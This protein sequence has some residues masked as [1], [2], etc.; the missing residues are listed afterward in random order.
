MS[1]IG[2]FKV[3][4][5]SYVVI[6]MLFLFIRLCIDESE[7]CKGVPLCSNKEDL[8]W[9]K[10]ASMWTVPENWTP[11]EIFYPNTLGPEP[12]K[13]CTTFLND[14]DPRGQWIHPDDMGD[15]KSYQ[16]I[17]RT[18]ENPFS[19]PLLT[20]TDDYR[21]LD[22]VNSICPNEMRRCLGDKPTQCVCE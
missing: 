4:V 6:F 18:D 21:W 19:K 11:I 20:A 14:K 16:C 10:T 15:G 1:K 12:Q 7:L 17:N 2:A 9:C 8:K 5:R 22:L 13:K 3:H